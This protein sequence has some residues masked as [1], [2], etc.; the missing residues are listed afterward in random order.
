MWAGVTTS[1]QVIVLDLTLCVGLVMSS[2]QQ[3]TQCV[4]VLDK[5][6]RRVVWDGLGPAENR[7]DAE[8]V[9]QTQHAPVSGEQDTFSAS[10]RRGLWRRRPVDTGGSPGPLSR[11]ATLD[12]GPHSWIEI[13]GEFAMLMVHQRQIQQERAVRDDD[14]LIVAPRRFRHAAGQRRWAS[15]NSDS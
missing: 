12:P 10:L 3:F 8:A 15:I 4:D 6:R 2:L 7:V 1:D 11:K 5:F 13:T 14:E 9:N